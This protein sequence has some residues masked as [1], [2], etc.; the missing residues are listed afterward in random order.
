MPLGMKVGLG[1]GD[2]VLDG[3]PAPS[4]KKGTEPLIFDPCLLWPNGWINQDGRLLGMEIGLS[5]GDFVLNGDPARPLNFR[6][7]FIVHC[8]KK[9]PT[10]TACYNVY[11]HSSIATIFGTNVAQKV[12]S[13]NVLYFPSSPN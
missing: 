5:P 13:Q 3:D 9:R 1:P 8:L 11:I 6:S 4:P 12:G 2:F 7:M 10:F